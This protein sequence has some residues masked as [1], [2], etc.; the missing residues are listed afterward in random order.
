MGNNGIRLAIREAGK[1]TH[2]FRLGACIT[3]QGKVVSFGHNKVG[4]RSNSDF[5][6]WKDS[7]HA[8]EA[9]IY[10]LLKRGQQKLLKGAT[11]YIARLSN[12]N[13]VV[14]AKPCDHCLRLI[15]SVGIKTIVYTTNTG[16][17]KDVL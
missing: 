4:H 10:K 5:S 3:R 16:E 2:N 12:T 7:V 14:L 11:I 6:R 9:A 8:E 15:E 17:I 13:A 1:S